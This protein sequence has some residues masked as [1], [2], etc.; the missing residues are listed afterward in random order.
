MFNEL[1]DIFENLQPLSE[2]EWKEIS[3]YFKKIEFNKGDIIT[4]E[5]QIETTIYFTVKGGTRAFYLK[6]GEEHCIDFRFENEFTG[7]YFSFL[8]QKP[9]RIYIQT[10]EPTIFYAISHVSLEKLYRKFKVV[11]RIGRLS[12]E[13]LVVKYHLR[14]AALMLDT[15]RDR[16]INLSNDKKQW[17]LRVPQKHLAS[18]INITPEYYSRLKKELF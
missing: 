6:D 3:S 8:Q 4:K 1:K 15:A 10:L 17:I 14:Q 9:S 18:Y 7:S 5:G 12:A 2:K 16:F 11:E 13:K